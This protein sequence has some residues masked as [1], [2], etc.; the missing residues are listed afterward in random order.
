MSRSLSANLNLS[1]CP[2]STEYHL[3]VSIV[4]FIPYRIIFPSH[5][6]EL[7]EAQRVSFTFVSRCL[8]FPGGA[9]VKNLPANA[10][11]ARD[12][13]VRKIP[14]SRKWQPAPVFLLGKFHGQGSLVGSQSQT[15]LNTH[16]CIPVP[17]TVPGTQLILNNWKIRPCLKQLD[18]FILTHLRMFLI[19][20]SSSIKWAS[21]CF[22][23]NPQSFRIASFQLILCSNQFAFYSLPRPREFYLYCFQWQTQRD[24]VFWWRTHQDRLRNHILEVPGNH[25]Q[26]GNSAY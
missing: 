5:A 8:G 21:V 6:H 7:I 20:I 12:C 15:Q 1:S 23:G 18:L 10:G 13:W 4:E 26:H 3:H 19:S 17:R 24:A 9:V 25:R 2:S 16:A 14:W 22:L 11:G